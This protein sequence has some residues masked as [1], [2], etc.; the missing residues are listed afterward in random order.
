MDHPRPGLRYISAD[1]LDT[2]RRPFKGFTVEDPSAEKLG[3]LE[4][5]VLD[6]TTARPYYA[7]VD[8]GSWFRSK[9][10][11]LPIGHVA[12]DSES[13]RLVADVGKERVKRFPGFELDTF[14]KLSDDDWYQMAQ[15]MVAACCPD[16]IIDESAPAV[17][18][19]EIW[20]HYRTPA[21]WDPGYSNPR[22][23][24]ERTATGSKH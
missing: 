6:V 20:S 8:G 23:V 19:F 4:G 13:R 21:W 3:T 16:E 24:T 7:V 12:L 9:H 2:G 17:A 15:Q 1:E 5:F 10:F 11:L 14:K 22:D 18:R